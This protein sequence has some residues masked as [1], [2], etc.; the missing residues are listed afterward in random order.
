MFHINVIR[1][2]M[3]PVRNLCAHL[4]P[5][6]I[7]YLSSNFTMMRNQAVRGLVDLVEALLFIVCVLSL[8]E[9]L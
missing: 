3:G 8:D 9:N 7:S 5:M 1:P 6:F 4:Q 2:N